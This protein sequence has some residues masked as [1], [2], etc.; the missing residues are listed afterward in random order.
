[1]ALEYTEENH[2]YYRNLVYSYIKHNNN[3]LEVFFESLDNETEQHYHERYALFIENINNNGTYTGD[4]E[5]SAGSLV[6]GKEINIYRKS[7]NGFE[8]IN[9]FTLNNSLEGVLLVR[10]RCLLCDLRDC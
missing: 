2:Q 9:K 5:I 7:F 10:N 3:Q 6:L 4:Y 1:M 8:L